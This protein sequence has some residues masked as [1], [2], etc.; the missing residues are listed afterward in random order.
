MNLKIYYNFHFHYI[1]LIADSLF[2]F[3]FV[4]QILKAFYYNKTS[5]KFQRYNLKTYFYVP[6]CC[7]IY[8]LITKKDAFH[9]S[10]VFKHAKLIFLFFLLIIWISLNFVIKNFVIHL[11][12]TLY[13]LSNFYE[14]YV[15]LYFLKIAKLIWFISRYCTFCIDLF[16]VIFLCYFNLNYCCIFLKIHNFLDSNRKFFFFREDVFFARYT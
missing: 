12:I 4:H 11:F 3:Y 8:L 5:A 9:I 15:S 16:L 7:V 10:F 6:W 1:L 13:H 2:V 14:F